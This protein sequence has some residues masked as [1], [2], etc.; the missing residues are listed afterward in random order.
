[1]AMLKRV[2]ICSP[3]SGDIPQNIEKATLYMTYALKC[4]TAPI[5]PHF[6]ALG[7]DDNNPKQ[8]EI[9]M[10]AGMSHLWFC[11]ELWVFGD[12][13]TSGMREEIRFCKSLNIPIKQIT[14]LK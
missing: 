5:V 6:Y 10:R 14:E 1:M 4:G 2:Y 3:L 8:R 11:D 13:I 9:G 12:E 7:L